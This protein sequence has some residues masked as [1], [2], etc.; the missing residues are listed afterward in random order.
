MILDEFEQSKSQLNF[1]FLDACRNSPKSFSRGIN[2]GLAKAESAK[3][4]LI[5][6]STAPGEVA[7]DGDG[8]N[9]PYTKNLVR[10]INN[11]N[12]QVELML[13][14][15]STQVL[16][17][18][19]GGQSPWYESSI[20]GNFCFNEI[21]GNCGFPDR[22]KLNVTGNWDGTWVSDNGVDGGSVRGTLTQ[23]NN[24]VNGSFNLTS[25]PCM[26]SGSVSG[27][28]FNSDI[29]MLFTSKNSSVEFQGSDITTNGMSGTYVSYGGK[30]EGDKGTLNMVKQPGGE[31]WNPGVYTVI[32]VY[33]GN[34]G[35]NNQK[36]VIVQ[37]RDTNGFEFEIANNWAD[38]LQD[39]FKYTSILK[40]EK[41]KYSTLGGYTR[42][43]FMNIS[44]VIK[45]NLE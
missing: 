27:S 43:W 13:K 19:K 37:L 24:S 44:A 8:R 20:S 4:V 18:T 1:L 36:A 16:E 3:G 12:I 39:R 2:S 35:N 32:D 29:E 14:D 33:W 21:N 34:K 25:S 17:D 26:S 41:I 11:S 30:C 22:D 42:D 10:N 15:V 9:S 6:Y 5:S 40:G 28:V 7:L 45:K 38:G 31:I 23:N